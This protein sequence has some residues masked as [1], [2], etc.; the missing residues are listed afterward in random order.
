MFMPR[1]PLLVFPQLHFINLAKKLILI[2]AKSP[3][4]GQKQ[5]GYKV[6]LCVSFLCILCSSRLQSCPP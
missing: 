5:Y 2:P 3:R 1:D 6:T 4:E